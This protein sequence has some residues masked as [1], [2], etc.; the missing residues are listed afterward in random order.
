MTYG[1]L[2]EGIGG[3]EMKRKEAERKTDK[4]EYEIKQKYGEIFQER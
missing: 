1:G 3:F 2:F 4:L